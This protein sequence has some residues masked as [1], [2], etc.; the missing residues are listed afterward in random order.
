MAITDGPP[1]VPAE[2][3]PSGGDQKPV[4]P[5]EP[6]AEAQERAVHRLLPDALRGPAA[7]GF[8]GAVAIAVGGALAGAAAPTGPDGRWLWDVP[9]IPVRP[10]VDLLPALVTF[11]GGLVLLSRA[12]LG[13]RRS[14]A[15]LDAPERR[16]RQAVLLVAVLW[17]L[18]LVLG[19]PLGSRD[20]YSYAAVGQLAE[21][22]L[23]P[24]QVGPAALGDGGV[25]DAVDPL[26]REQPTP[27]GP[28]FLAVA[29]SAAGLVGSQAV[30]AVLLYRLL[31]LAGLGLVA[32]FLPRL[33]V[34]FGGDGA[35]ALVLALA[36]PLTM[37]HLVS[38]AHNEALLAG[39]LVTGLALGC[40][41]PSG[42]GPSG[43]ALGLGM[44]AAGGRLPARASSAAYVGGLVLCSLAAGIKLPAALGVVWLAWNRPAPGSPLPARMRSVLAAG[45][46]GFATLAT[47]AE[48]AG[49][50]WGWTETIGTAG[51]VT[52][53]LSP[54]TWLGQ[55]VD[56]AGSALG[57]AHT[58]GQ[59]A[60]V[61]P[62]LGLALAALLATGLLVR[63]HHTGLRPL[64]VAFVGV[65][66]LLP[67][68]HPWYLVWGLVLLAAVA[69]DRARPFLAL[70][71]VT[72]FAV[73][74]G[75]PDLGTQLLAERSVWVVLLSALALAPLAVPWSRAWWRSWLRAEQGHR[76]ARAG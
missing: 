69:G 50:G 3:D 46:V 30:T 9:T 33:A 8:V 7:L 31:A 16:R 72:S 43:L 58:G 32:A 37:L 1:A 35:V 21:A 60:A 62:M 18:P 20:V 71:V 34:R 40:C 42:T 38:G 67:A 45:V 63:S 13:L 15:A 55:A 25:L 19:P 49:T 41:P 11:Y 75:G 59:L 22:G 76:A 36:N 53:Y 17:A 24:Y 4:R 23:D 66:L 26:W 47:V 14:V 2:P 29:R 64:G 68:V 48:V 65:A 12:W 57:L 73:L 61:V 44:T 74:P 54:T 52:A 27:Y 70:S 56:M 6:D 5:H 39:L 28:S 51:E 10:V